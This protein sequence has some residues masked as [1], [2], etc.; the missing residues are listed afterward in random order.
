MQNLGF[1]HKFVWTSSSIISH[2]SPT[3]YHPDLRQNKSVGTMV[4]FFTLISN[5]E[6]L[7]L[8]ELSLFIEWSCACL[9]VCIETS[10]AIQKMGSFVQHKE[11]LTQ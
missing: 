2:R 3:N 6:L 8:E 9:C 11:T 7:L 4:V 1:Y 10:R 5:R